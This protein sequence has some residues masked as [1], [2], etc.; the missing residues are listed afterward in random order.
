MNRA[1]RHSCLLILALTVV[2][3]IVVAMKSPACA[4]SRDPIVRPPSLDN[5]EKIEDFINQ[6][7]RDNTQRP[8]PFV[9]NEQMGVDQVAQY[10][11]EEKPRPEYGFGKYDIETL[12]LQGIWRQDEEI[13]AFFKTPDN[14]SML[15]TI[16]DE[17]YDGRIVEINLQ[18]KYVKFLQELKRKTSDEAIDSSEPD[19]IFTEKIVRIRN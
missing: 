3:M 17:A 8:D 9:R 7:L 6:V 4:Q 14:K 5:K 19:T 15:V 10:E 11:V 13:Y 2:L 1:G 16:G 12:I 18:G